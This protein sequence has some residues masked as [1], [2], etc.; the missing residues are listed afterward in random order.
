MST[1]RRNDWQSDCI[2]HSIHPKNEDIREIEEYNCAKRKMSKNKAPAFFFSTFY[3]IL[4]DLLSSSPRTFFL[5]PSAASSSSV[6]RNI[7]R[8]S[9]SF[10]LICCCSSP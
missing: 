4:R 6:S 3:S 7:I 10:F 1:K 5:R 2:H 8:N 9:V